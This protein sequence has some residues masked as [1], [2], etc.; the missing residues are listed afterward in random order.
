M[1]KKCNE[2][3]FQQVEIQKKQLEQLGIFTDYD[4]YYITSNKHYEAEQIRIFAEMVRK[5]LIYR[6]WKPIYW[7]CSHATALAEAEVEYLEKKDTSLYFKI[8]STEIS[9]FFN[10][11]KVSLLV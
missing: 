7:S 11:E 10:K 5:N 2:Y 4:K 8:Y 6:G 3:A 9:R 1:R